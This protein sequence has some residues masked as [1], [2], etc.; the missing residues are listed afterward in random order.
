MLKQHLLGLLYVNLRLNIISW[1]SALSK[2][3]AL[4]I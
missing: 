4:K 3:E 2:R 1:F